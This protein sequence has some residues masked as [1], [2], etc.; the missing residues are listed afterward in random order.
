M[1]NEDLLVLDGRIE[2]RLPDGRMRIHLE[3]DYRIMALERGHVLRTGADAG[4]QG[5]RH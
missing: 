2:K 4:P 5:G 1:G 3:D